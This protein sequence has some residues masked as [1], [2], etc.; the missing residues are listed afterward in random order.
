MK[1]IID[2]NQIDNAFMNAW[3]ALTTKHFKDST[4][5]NWPT[6]QEQSDWWKEYDVKLLPEL[7]ADHKGW[8]RVE[9][10]NQ[11]ALTSFVTHWDGINY[12]RV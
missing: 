3:S 6:A 8:D 11:E 7:S 2:I 4:P 12:E 9:F 1:R 5:E 10:K